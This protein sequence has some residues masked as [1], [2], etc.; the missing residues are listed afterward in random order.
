MK[1]DI[2]Q[3]ALSQL[4]WKQIDKNRSTQIFGYLHKFYFLFFI[5]KDV[6]LFLKKN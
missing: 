3:V 6:V 2:T 4:L 1:V 5:A